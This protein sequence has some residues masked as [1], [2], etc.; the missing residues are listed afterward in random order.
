MNNIEV[1]QGVVTWNGTPE[2]FKAIEVLECNGRHFISR[3]KVNEIMRQWEQQVKAE[4][5]NKRNGLKLFNVKGREV[6]ALN[7]ANAERK[8]SKLC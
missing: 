2:D 6:W 5:R 4:S 1:I 7:R 3:E 8:A